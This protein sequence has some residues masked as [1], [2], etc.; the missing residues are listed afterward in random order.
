MGTAQ[1]GLGI[2]AKKTQLPGRQEISCVKKLVYTDEFLYINFFLE[3]LN[4]EMT[5][6]S[7]SGLGYRM[8]KKPTVYF[9]VEKCS[10]L[11]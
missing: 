6:L 7:T 4:A 3:F 1:I 2:H 10:L 5:Y 11:W 8:V 9:T